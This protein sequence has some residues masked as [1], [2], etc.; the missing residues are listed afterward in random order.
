MID[1]VSSALKATPTEAVNKVNSLYAELKSVQAELSALK[2]QAAASSLDDMASNAVDV[3]GIKVI[4]SVVDGADINTLRNMG[5]AM[6]DKVENSVGLFITS[7]DDK[8]TMLCVAS[9][10]AVEKGVHCGKIV[11]ELSALVGGNG[12]GKPDSAQAGGKDASG[13]KAAT[14]KIY[15]LVKEQLG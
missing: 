8:V 6:K 1:E 12:G 2:A 15:E 7:G 3:N 13:I 4:A 10:S 9:K 14:E 5:D 11:K